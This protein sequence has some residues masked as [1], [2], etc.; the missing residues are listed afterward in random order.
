MSPL[1][2][3]TSSGVLLALWTA[4]VPAAALPAQAGASL[5]L[6]AVGEGHPFDRAAQRLAEGRGAE[7][8]R[9]DPADLSPLRDRI[10]DLAPRYVTL[11]V[12]PEQLD[13]DLQRR[14]LQFATELDDDPFVDFSYGYVTGRDGAAALALVERGLARR[15]VAPERVV[16]VG[17]GAR[18][19]T[20]RTQPF[21]LRTG[22]IP[23]EWWSVAGERRFPEEGRDRAFMAQHLPALRGSDAVEFIGHGWPHEVV[24]GPEARD[25]AGVD[26]DGAVALNVACFTGVTHRWFERDYR[27]GAVHLRTVPLEQS[28]CLAALDTGLLGYTAYLCPRPAGPELD[29]DLADLLVGGASLGDARRRDYDETVLGF[30][31]YGEPRLDLARFEDGARF[32][33]VRDAVRDMM[34]EGATGGVLFGDPEVVPFTAD[35]D[36]APVD[37]VCAPSERGVRV[38]IAVPRALLG[39]QCADQTAKWGSKMAMKVHARVA[40][41]RAVPTEVQVLELSLGGTAVASRLIWA[42]EEDRGEHFVQLKVY[43]SRDD[44][45]RGDVRAVVQVRTSRDPA[46]LVKRGGEIHPAPSAPAVAAKRASGSRTLDADILACA[47]RRRVSE[48]AM[49]ITLDAS[50]QLRG[51]AGVAPDIQQRFAAL[52]SE[53]YRGVCV[54]IEVGHTHA[55]VR[56]LLPL[57]WSPGDERDLLVLAQRDDLPNWADWTALAGLGASDTPEVRRYLL[58]ALAS[59]RDAGRYMSIA[60]ALA[61][62]G[63]TEVAAA[64]G[65]RI[66]EQRQGW[67]GVEG[68]LIDVLGSLGGDD[69]VDRLSQIAST[70]GGDRQGDQ[71]RKA[72]LLHLDRLAP[73][74]AARLRR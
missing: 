38:E 67:S 20:R 37:V 5:V 56:R 21:G 40:L 36:R 68:Y 48:E 69:A 16:R 31:A 17:G 63:M 73:E 2:R 46:A 62:L 41:G 9:F 11:V 43:W 70:R 64:V 72:A 74:V 54:L 50:A 57:V 45:P 71:A 4:A 15:P 55:Y 52:G 28:F 44:M 35:V 34:L 18:E 1:S 12:T 19:S 26:L 58:G 59:E 61:E 39:T 66:L 49:Q 3:L 7:I 27:A 32:A 60:E 65:D 24:G 47:A 14:F 6:A 25:L 23:G 33:P 10:R 51:V 53:G 42:F 29:T 22:A 13:F 8:V 30:L